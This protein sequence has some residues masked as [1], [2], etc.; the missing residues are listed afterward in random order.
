[1]VIITDS[2]TKS[3]EYVL[4]FDGGS[5]G[6]P[7][8][9]GSGYVIYHKGEEIKA[10]CLFAG[11]N[12]TNNYAE[13]VGLIIGLRQ[14][15]K[16]GIKHLLVQGDS[17]LVINQMIG[18]YKCKSENLIHLYT[19][20]QQFCEKFDCIQFQHIPRSKNQRADALSNMAMDSARTGLN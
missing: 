8:I 6:N 2:T 11:H 4:Q 5:R 10:N 13:Y 14:A 15:E 16:L 1:M 12:R 17:L 7:G 9:A 3:A 18:V 19:R 20:A